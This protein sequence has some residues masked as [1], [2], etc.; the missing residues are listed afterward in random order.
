GDFYA[1]F[2]DDARAAF[3]WAWPEMR[4]LAGWLAGDYR[5]TTLEGD[6]ASATSLLLEGIERDRNKDQN[7]AGGFATLAMDVVFANSPARRYL[8]LS[9]QNMCHFACP[10]PGRD[11]PALALYR[12][13]HQRA[14]A[15]ARTARSAVRADEALLSALAVDAFG[16][17]FLS[18]LFA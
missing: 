6:A 16:C 9:S 1:H 2:D 7:G 17:H 12:A 10:E 13:Y 18:D 4:G 5:G 14:I 8:A 15:S 3:A 11:N